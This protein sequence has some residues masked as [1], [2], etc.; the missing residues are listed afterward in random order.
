[1]RTAVVAV[2]TCTVVLAAC[3]GRASP[4]ALPADS[5]IDGLVT[6]VGACTAGAC[7]DEPVSASI[8][9]WSGNRE[10]RRVDASG[11]GQFRIL[12]PPGT[13]RVEAVAG[14]G[15]QR[16]RAEQIVNVTEGRLA[17]VRLRLE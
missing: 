8:T 2:L 15:G 12:L 14:G 13:Y 1:M 7:P 10:I 11:A 4:I 5:G 3:G 6:A 9:V 16:R 17:P